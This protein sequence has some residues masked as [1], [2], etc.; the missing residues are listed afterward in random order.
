MLIT[1]LSI[2]TGVAIFGIIFFLI[3]KKA[4]KNKLDFYLKKNNRKN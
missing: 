4:L 2:F 3:V 1:V